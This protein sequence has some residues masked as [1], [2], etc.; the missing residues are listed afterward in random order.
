MG[1]CKLRNASEVVLRII[2]EGNVDHDTKRDTFGYSFNLMP[3]VSLTLDGKP[4][5]LQIFPDDA[6]LYEDVESSL[7]NVKYENL[8]YPRK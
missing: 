1:K 6:L 3:E 5:K 8:M 7:R 4:S 2:F